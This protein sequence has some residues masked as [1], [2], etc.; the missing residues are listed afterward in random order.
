M[1][2]F[3][4]KKLGSYGQSKYVIGMGRTR[5][6]VASVSREYNYLAKTNA[7]PLFS[8]FQFSAPSA[9]ILLK[10]TPGEGQ[11]QIDLVE[12][13]NGGSPITNYEYST[14]NGLTWTPFTP[15]TTS[16]RVTISGLTNGEIYKIK[17]RGV[18][19]V[20]TGIASSALI[21]TLSAI[22]PAPTITDVSPTTLSSVSVS[23][24][25][26]PNPKGNPITNYYYS[27]DGGQTFVPLSSPQ[28]SSPITITG[29]TPEVNYDIV[30]KAYSDVD[31]FSNASLTSLSTPFTIDFEATASSIRVQEGRI[32]IYAFDG[33]NSTSWVTNYS[34]TTTSYGALG[35]YTGLTNNSGVFIGP[36]YTTNVVGVGDVSG[37]WIQITFPFPFLLT[38]H[39]Y[40]SSVDNRRVPRVFY[41]VGSN[42]GIT[43]N[44]VQYASNA[45]TNIAP[46]GLFNYNVT[47][48]TYYTHYR[49]VVTNL[50]NT[51][52]G[53]LILTNWN[54]TGFA[55][56]SSVKILSLNTDTSLLYYYPFDNTFPGS[57]L[58]NYNRY[59]V[60][61][62]ILPPEL[63]PETVAGGFYNFNNQGIIGTRCIEYANGQFPV[64]RNLTLNAD[65]VSFGGWVSCKKGSSYSRFFGFVPSS[66]IFV[67]LQA[68]NGRY[69][70]DATNNYYKPY[71]T[72]VAAFDDN[73]NHMFV[74]IDGSIIKYYVNGIL[75]Y[76]D[77]RSTLGV[78]NI[79]IFAVGMYGTFNSS[80]MDDLRLYSR[81]L[82]SAEV[83]QLYR[84]SGDLTLPSNPTFVKI[85]PPIIT[86]VYQTTLNSVALEIAQTSSSNA[87]TNYYYSID[88]GATFTELSPVDLVSPLVITGLS[89]EV[90]YNITLKSYNPVD[91]LSSSSNIVTTKIYS[92][93]TDTDLVYYFPY[94]GTFENKELWNY[95]K[96]FVDGSITNDIYLITGTQ[97]TKPP[98][99]VGDRGLFNDVGSNYITYNNKTINP[100]H[101]TISLWTKVSDFIPSG[102]GNK[103]LFSLSFGTVVANGY[104]TLQ[105]GAGSY[106]IDGDNNRY[107]GYY[108]SIEFAPAGIFH[109][110]AIVANG[111]SIVY[112][113]NGNLV[114]TQT[115]NPLTTPTETTEIIVGSANSTYNVKHNTDDFRLYNRSL[116]HDEILQIY[117]Y[118]GSLATS[119]SDIKFVK[120]APPII[121]SI[122]PTSLTSVNVEFSQ[123]PGSIAVT[124]YYYSINGGTF[125]KLTPTDIT[126]PVSI[127]GLTAG[128]NYS[129]SLKAYNP[130]DGLSNESNIVTTQIITPP[131]I[132]SI[133]STSFSTATVEFTQI[134]GETPITNYYYSLD[135]GVNFVP[136]SPADANSPIVITG[137]TPDQTY[138]IAIK[139]YS[140]SGQLLSNASNV[141][142]V[143]VLSVNA[144][145]TLVVYHPFDNTIAGKELWNYNRYFVDG[146]IEN[147]ISSTSGTY[148]IPPS[149]S[150]ESTER[151]VNSIVARYT[152]NNNFNSIA[153]SPELRL[154]AAVAYSGK[155]GNKFIAT[156]PDGITWTA[157]N[158]AIHILPNC[159]STGTYTFTTTS[160]GNLTGTQQ[161]LNI[162]SGSGTI[163]NDTY[164]TNITGSSPLW[165]ITTNKVVSGLSESSVVSA[166]TRWN[167]ICWGGS[168]TK[169]F[170]AVAASGGKRI[171]TSTDGIT[172]T[173]SEITGV[174]IDSGFLTCVCWSPE[175][176]LFVALGGV[177]T[178][179]AISSPDGIN[180]TNNTT[181]TPNNG[182]TSVCWSA[183]LGLFAAVARTGTGNRVMTSPDGVNWTAR[184][185]TGNDKDWRSICW[186]KDLNMFVAVSYSGTN[187]VMYSYDG[188][189]WTAVSGTNMDAGSWNSVVYVPELK[190]F[191][192]IGTPN[193]PRLMWSYD[194]LNW[195]TSTGPGLWLLCI[196]WAPELGTFAYGS[197]TSTSRIFSS[198]LNLR[199]QVTTNKVV[200]P[201]SLYLLDGR[202]DFNRQSLQPNKFS[203]SLW[204]K[205][206]A[207]ITAGGQRLLFVLDFGGNNYIVFQNAAGTYRFERVNYAVGGAISAATAPANVWHHW[208]YI[209]DETIAYIYLNGN[210]L[211]AE[212][213]GGIPTTPT[214][215]TALYIGRV[216]GTPTPASYT[217]ID[218]FRFYNNRALNGDEVRALYN[219]RGEI[220]TITQFTTV[221][222]TSWTAPSGV[223]SVEYLVVGGGGGGGGSYDTGAGG[224]GG[225]GLVLY[226]TRSVV[227]GTSYEIEV[228][229]GGAGGIGV[230]NGGG[231]GTSYAGN[232]SKFDTII[233]NGGGAGNGSLIDRTGAGGEQGNADTLTAPTGGKG[234]RPTGGASG[235]GGGGGMGSAGSSG[236]ISNPPG[237]SGV[238]YS[239]SGSTQSYGAGGRGGT[240]NNNTNGANASANTGNGG[241]GASAISA[242]GSNGGKGGSGIVIL[243]Y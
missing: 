90:T 192:A 173:Q 9:P 114:S 52:A 162:I 187:R 117:R 184:S 190:I 55:K 45:N 158:S 137:L 77:T 112:Y 56:S 212:N 205:V 19:P 241:Q 10:A 74:V 105:N 218:D 3:N 195:T 14:N 99:V 172:W 116:T 193:S 12:G 169:R 198:E 132:T 6:T 145:P 165:T 189:T 53:Y 1:S 78:R 107:I 142:S 27:L 100:N 163:P 84:Y 5:S 120:F 156:S 32:P 206:T 30:I 211:I 21:V 43:W 209:V 216:L 203:F 126:S 197:T 54:L 80:L 11:V 44:V 228:G 242:D 42:D 164:I 232:A 181:S 196:C 123:P 240:T 141:A 63:V 40:S 37:E 233:A 214:T 224:G 62:S 154:F 104:I 46:Q 124:E 200:G 213:V 64:F 49:M 122:Y 61:G 108:P 125:I 57:E 68:Y 4:A 127:T 143:K 204:T 34:S 73:W 18:N 201:S 148:I 149:V 24:T 221:G 179:R 97:T 72:N 235:G 22:V 94:D 41:I 208:C 188:I 79:S 47:S 182:W 130:V 95:N 101:F 88:G 161:E 70:F 175:L 29:L 170:V 128:V 185:T 15:A 106:R 140:S 113:L 16:S 103:R 229:D 121:T 58:K 86:S 210:L 75:V 239:I 26:S 20:G 23:F 59:F 217:Y 82:S 231:D 194:G 91:G 225:G 177:G 96:Y 31:G 153:W 178:V 60:N 35:V 139:A 166:D 155:D 111:T 131:V 65:N 17:M 171:L 36:I 51:S 93:N 180:W 183:E 83:L 135:G 102:Q 144:E 199:I 110:W 207:F 223:T 8:L 87:P 236:T 38:S 146:S 226:G 13:Y 167:S 238:T 227:P 39:S 159:I 69:N 81:S 33:N 168:T 50:F 237:G 119:P 66:S 160:I 157:R 67:V 129:I 230:G 28:M 215:P 136:L 150:P 115:I 2:G 25:Q 76:N 7:T 134:E 133:T 234:G 220:P 191:A 138:S 147:N 118:R 152:S 176:N 92:P 98:E 202:V 243:K 186:S 109:H 85:R 151:L 174:S 48:T 71:A 219:Y 222:T 89:P